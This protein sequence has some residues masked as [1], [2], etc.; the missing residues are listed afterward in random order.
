MPSLGNAKRRAA[1]ST[2]HPHCIELTPPPEG[3]PDEI[4]EEIIRFLERCSGTFDLYGEIATN[5][6]FIR[7]CFE[8]PADAD[9]FH[10]QFAAAAKK[11]TI[12]R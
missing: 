6:A 8:N 5:D 10:R 12:T 11:A 2:E 1:S 7:Y 3:F 9:A 4:E